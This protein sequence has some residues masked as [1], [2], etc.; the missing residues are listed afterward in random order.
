MV[1]MLRSSHFEYLLDF[2][3]AAYHIPTGTIN[4]VFPTGYDLFGKRLDKLWKF[5]VHVQHFKLESLPETDA[6]LEQWLIDRWI[7]K[8]ARLAKWEMAWPETEIGECVPG[9]V[10][11]LRGVCN[12]VGS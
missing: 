5:H 9:P 10:A 7:E 2:T 4:S 12:Q 11:S 8:D 1:H 6:E 3:V